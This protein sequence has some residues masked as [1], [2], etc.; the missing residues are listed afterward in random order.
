[1]GVAILAKEIRA[2]SWPERQKLLQILDREESRQ[3]GVAARRDR[4]MDR[5]AGRTIPVKKFFHAV[6]ARLRRCG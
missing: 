2:L 1:M 5:G 4:E 3:V 6:R